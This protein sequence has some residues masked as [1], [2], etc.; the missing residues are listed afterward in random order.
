MNMFIFVVV[1]WKANCNFDNYVA[2]E[3]KP[4]RSRIRN[5]NSHFSNIHNKHA[6]FLTPA[7]SCNKSNFSQHLKLHPTKSYLDIPSVQ[8]HL[9]LITVKCLTQLVSSLQSTCLHYLNLYFLIT[10]LSGSND[11]QFSKLCSFLSFLSKV[12]TVQSISYC[13]VLTS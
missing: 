3:S 8:F 1:K 2:V 10:G 11:Q 6:Q 9:T 7:Y 12:T 13:N 4:N 5:C